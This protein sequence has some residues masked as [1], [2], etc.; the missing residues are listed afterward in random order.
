[1][2]F[3][4]SDK[5]VC[6]ETPAADFFGMFRRVGPVPEVGR[7]YVIDKIIHCAISTGLALVGSTSFFIPQDRECGYH[8]SLF[9]KLEEV[10]AENRAK[11]EQ[12]AFIREA[13]KLINSEP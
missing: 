11:N 1:M 4:V 8:H 7:V 2:N 3:K 5:V 13:T 6:I 10:Q 9:R 12:E